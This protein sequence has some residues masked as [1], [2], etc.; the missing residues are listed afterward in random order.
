MPFCSRAWS[1]LPG[2]GLGQGKFPPLL[3]L[4]SPLL[5]EPKIVGILGDFRRTRVRAPS[6]SPENHLIFPFHYYF[7]FFNNSSHFWGS[8]LEL[9]LR[10]WVTA[11]FPRQRQSPGTAPGSFRLKDFK[12]LRKL[13]L[14]IYS[15][16][17]L[18]SSFSGGSRIAGSQR[19]SR[20]HP[21]GRGKVS[22]NRYLKYV[23]KIYK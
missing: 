13:S 7:P 8:S 2:K 22:N 11:K 21:E 5:G 14:M 16:K 20:S 19:E 3:C 9:L 4:T 23:N 18:I 12:A 6:P 17:T 10:K 15:C 1:F